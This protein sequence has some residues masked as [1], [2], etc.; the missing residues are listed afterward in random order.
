[1]LAD[2]LVAVVALTNYLAN[3]SGK[4]GL[5]LNFSK[6]KIMAVTRKFG[7]L[8]QTVVNNNNIEVV[9]NLYNGILVVSYATR[10]GRRPT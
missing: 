2:T 4:F 10:V 5:K 7:P 3:E 8:E 1:M 9:E 6:I